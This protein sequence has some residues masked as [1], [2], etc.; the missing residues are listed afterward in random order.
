MPNASAPKA[1]WVEVWLSPQTMVMP[2]C[3]RPSSG[4]MTWT[5]PS[6]PDARSRR[7]A[8][9]TRR[10]SRERLDLRPR[11]LVGD[12]RR[13]RS[14]RCGRSSRWSG[15]AGGPSVRRAAARRT[16]AATS[17]RGR[18][19]GRCRAAAGS[20]ASSRTTCAPTPSRTASSACDEDYVRPGSPIVTW[21]SSAPRNRRSSSASLRTPA[22]ILSLN[23]RAASPRPPDGRACACASTLRG[24]G[25][26]RAR[27]V[28]SSLVPWLT[29]RRCSSATR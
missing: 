1:P 26:R 29:W 17:P 25:R 19:A 15:R 27:P 14:G 12:R 10:S 7:A 28:R 23:A 21:S 11:E 13:R 5:M 9:R 22:T 18:G 2:G 6:R 24:H 4:P 16:P 8:P 20:P 3:V